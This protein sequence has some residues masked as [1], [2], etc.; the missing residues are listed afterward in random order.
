MSLP[1]IISKPYPRVVLIGRT[2]AGK[3]TLFN[4]L[5]ESDKAIISPI[6]NTTRDQNRGL[7]HWKGSTCELIDTGGLDMSA[8]D[9]LDQDIQKQVADALHQAKAVMLIVDGQGECLPQDIE[10]A[11]FLKKHG[12][13]VVVVINKCDKV[14]TR[15]NAPATFAAL[16]FAQL[17]PCSAKNSSGTGDVLDA[18]FAIIHHTASPTASDQSSMRMILAGQPNVG[19]SSLFNTLIGEERVIVSPLPHTTRDA[20]DTTISYEDRLITLIDTAGLRRQNRVGHGTERQI[21]T[22]ST[23]ATKA[24]IINA[25]V[26]VLLIEAQRRVVHQD[27]ALIDYIINHGKSFVLV[28]NKWDLIPEKDTVTMNKYIKYYRAHFQFA[29]YVPILFTSVMYK[30]RVLKILD[31]VKEIYD[32][33]HTPMSQADLDGVLRKFES[34]HPRERRFHESVKP[35]KPLEITALQQTSIAPVHFALVTPR[36]K[37]VAPALINRLEK[38]IREVCP[39]TGV[40]IYIDIVTKV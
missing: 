16:P 9:P 4:R 35:K 6:A 1:K 15:Q 26:V 30:Q 8:L 31:T 3:S 38:M 13:P 11:L 34:T 14:R 39:F 32:Y 27:K 23:R 25:D 2:N 21:E 22:L 7:V 33:Q 36:T 40:P 17:I 29:D 12:V 10:S 28:A 19:K 37:S 18:L 24:N 5:T 20:N